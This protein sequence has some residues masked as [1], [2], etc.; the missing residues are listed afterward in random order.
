MVSRARPGRTTIRTLVVVTVLAALAWALAESQTIQTEP[1]SLQL[2]LADG[3]EGVTAREDGPVVR[4]APDQDWGGQ[5]EVTIAG[6]AAL[7]DTLKDRLLGLV[8]LAVGANFP[9][10]PGV[11]EI[12]LREAL[13]GSESFRGSGVTIE[14]VSPARLRVEVGQLGVRELPVA[15]RVPDGVELDGVPAATPTTVRFIA[16][17]SVL[18]EYGPS[19]V[20][21]A[22]LGERELGPLVPGRAETVRNVAVRLPPGTDLGW[23][24]RLD[25]A[26]VD[27]SVTVRSKSSTLTIPTMPVQVRMSPTEAG[28][29]SIEIDQADQDLIDV[30]LTGPQEQLDRIR[31]REIRPA[32]EI[33]LSFE[34]LEAGLETA[35]ARVVDLPAGVRAEI[36]NDAVRLTITRVSQDDPAVSGP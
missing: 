18:D 29:W 28:R 8:T 32:A 13:R 17:R 1:L 11:H 36:P 26:R 31:R 34:D 24:T 4:V 30:V 6:S 7:T 9:S 14:S 27:V 21:S 5:V 23:S 3:S 35:R 25:P 12:D 15:V 33:V 16:P 2:V 20:V 19:A 22:E 10:E